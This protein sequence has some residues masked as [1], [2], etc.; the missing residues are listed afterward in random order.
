MLNKLVFL[1]GLLSLAACGEAANA[2][3]ARVAD[4]F[5]IL[6]NPSGVSPGEGWNAC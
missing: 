3:T 6:T 5:A 1:A 2:T 4:A